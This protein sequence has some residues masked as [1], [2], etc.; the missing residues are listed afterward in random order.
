MKQFTITA[1]CE[2]DKDMNPLGI[3]DL[4]PVKKMLL[5]NF[6]GYTILPSY[7]GWLDGN[8]NLVEEQ[9]VVFVVCYQEFKVTGA[10]I[11]AAAR[12]IRDYLK[13]H[14]VVLNN[15]GAVLFI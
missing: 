3:T 7:G 4:D 1:G 15:D 11:E 10:E 6:G 13:Q 14:S 2:Y 5:K 8:D 9:G 12:S